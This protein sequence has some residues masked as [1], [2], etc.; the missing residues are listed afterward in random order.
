M[1]RQLSALEQRRNGHLNRCKL[2]RS[3]NSIGPCCS[4]KNLVDKEGV[5][6]EIQQRKPEHEA[7]LRE[8]R[9]NELFMSRQGG[10]G[11]VREE[12][13]QLVKTDA[14]HNPTGEKNQQVI[15]CNDQRNCS[16]YDL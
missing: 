12:H 7:K 8:S 16:Q 10:P 1:K 6:L 9:K 5:V 13:Q 2:R 11:P 15:G 14:D 4:G 3:R